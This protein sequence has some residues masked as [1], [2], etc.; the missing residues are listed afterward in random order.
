MMVYARLCLVS[1]SWSSSIVA[2]R[3]TTVD[4]LWV[5]S[6]TGRMGNFAAVAILLRHCGAPSLRTL[7]LLYDYP[8]SSGTYSGIY[9]QAILNQL[10]AG[11]APKVREL[12]FDR[13]NFDEASLVAFNSAIARGHF[14]NLSILYWDHCPFAQG[15]AVM[16][17]ESL[18][19]HGAQLPRLRSIGWNRM[20]SDDTL[21]FA[22]GLR[23]G[24]CPVLEE[25]ELCS[26]EI[27]EQTMEALCEALTNGGESVTSCARTLKTLVL[28]HLRGGSTALFL[29]WT[30]LC[31]ALTN[32]N[33][34][35]KL[36]RLDLS[37]NKIS[38]EVQLQVQTALETRRENMGP[39]FCLDEVEMD[40]R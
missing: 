10:A 11:R 8:S 38:L 35:P 34:A 28:Y 19:E 16:L 13:M 33:F 21:S 27:S 29:V 24:A 6:S 4:D 15:S 2:E 32:P 5:T 22:H 20:G 3:M 23:H 36:E 39:A 30:S 1:K 17:M 37:L 9:L 12:E 18:R 40:Q 31:N 26:C 14:V 7:S 25:L